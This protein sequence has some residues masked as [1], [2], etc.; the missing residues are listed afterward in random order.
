[1]TST[2]NIEHARIIE[3][4]ELEMA[5]VEVQMGKRKYSKISLGKYN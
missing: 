4:C 2:I 5:V 1:V 3:S